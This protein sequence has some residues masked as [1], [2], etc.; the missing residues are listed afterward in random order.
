MQ[1]SDA[2]WLYMGSEVMDTERLWRWEVRGGFGPALPVVTETAELISDWES[3]EELD[4]EG[5]SGEEPV[6]VEHVEDEGGEVVVEDREEAEVEQEEEQ[7]RVSI[8]L[9]ELWKDCRENG[10]TMRLQNSSVLF[11][12]VMGIPTLFS[13]PVS[14]AHGSFG[15]FDQTMCENYWNHVHDTKEVHYSYT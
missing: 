12:I 14:S 7:E 9:H 6:M 5:V 3:E 10:T 8:M 11:T 4:L 15:S 13:E 1:E 2:C